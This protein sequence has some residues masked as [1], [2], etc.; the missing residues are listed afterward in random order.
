[1][2]SLD[3][4]KKIKSEVEEKEFEMKKLKKQ[5]KLELEKNNAK[6]LTRGKY[7]VN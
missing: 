1:M 5:Q 2:K 7:S 3:D 4:L 6:L